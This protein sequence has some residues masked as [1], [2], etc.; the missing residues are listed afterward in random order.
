MSFK[1]TVLFSFLALA[2]G[3]LGAYSTGEEEEF[4]E[5]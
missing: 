2:G 1:L 3:F 5:D 4:E